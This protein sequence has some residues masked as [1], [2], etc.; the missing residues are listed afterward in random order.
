MKTLITIILF[1]A[2]GVCSTASA[3]DARTMFLTI[4]QQLLPLLSYNS[5]AD[6]VDYA[7][8]NMTAR[9][10]NELYGESELKVLTADYLLLET[11]SSSTMQ[12]KLLPIGD[13][14]V[15]CVV[16]S[17]KAESVDSCISFYDSS[18]NE[19][20]TADYFAVPSIRDFFAPEG[21]TADN[22]A[23]CDIYLVSLT[24]NPTDCSLVAE[25]TMP[26]YMS[27]DEA[28]EIAPLLRKLIY[29]WENGRFV[30]AE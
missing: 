18:W 25:Y 11:T 14:T 20:A 24:L 17:V 19:L 16:K 4:P 29:V 1:L 8:A 22:L 6:L 9:T 21:A 23:I 5:R 10:R 30:L 28:A 13:K 2:C 7:E 3:Q 26:A 27:E 15:V 12:M